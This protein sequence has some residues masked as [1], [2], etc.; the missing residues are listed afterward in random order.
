MTEPSVKKAFHRVAWAQYAEGVDVAAVVKKLDESKVSYLTH[1][2]STGVLADLQID[3]FTFHMGLNT[4]P[5]VGRV[6]Y[7]PAVASTLDRLVK[8]AAGAKALAIKL[9]QELLDVAEAENGGDKAGDA[10]IIQKEGEA[11]TSGLKEAGSSVVEEI[12][13]VI[14]EKQGL[15]G[16]SEGFTEE[17]KIAKVSFP[18]VFMGSS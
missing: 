4:A 16:D 10:T 2:K 18:S 3:N 13:G 8:D 7:A 12:L 1:L 9:E 14:L 17:Q 6:R 11:S 15:S 5:T